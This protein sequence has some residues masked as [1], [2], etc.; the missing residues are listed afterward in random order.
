[1]RYLKFSRRILIAGMFLLFAFAEAE[2]Q[3]DLNIKNTA[4]QVKPG[5]YECI[6]YLE[7]SKDAA[8]AI[9]SV[10]YTLPPGYP[11][12]RLLARKK[13]AGI[14]GYFSS[15][16]FTTTEEAIISVQIERRGAHPSTTN[17]KFKLKLFGAK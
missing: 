12:R 5:V 11:N 9:Y 15:N 8:N 14:R 13:R 16:P 7:I 1:M 10:T 3:G 17:I 2:G 6:V 4:R